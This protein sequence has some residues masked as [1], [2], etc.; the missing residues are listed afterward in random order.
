MD[1]SCAPILR[2]MAPQQSAKFR[3]AFFGQFRTSL[4]NDSVA[5][6]ASILDPVF[7]IADTFVGG[8]TRFGKLRSKFCK[9]DAEF[10][11]NRLLR[12]VIIDVYSN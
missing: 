4:K 9:A 7:E 1:C 5:N 12:M 8:A 3:T 10:A 6:Y 2:Q 11:G